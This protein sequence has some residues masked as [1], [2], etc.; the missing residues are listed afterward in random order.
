MEDIYNDMYVPVPGLFG[1]RFKQIKRDLQPDLLKNYLIEN[2]L[3]NRE[4][5][6]YYLS[7]Y[8]NF[9]SRL[10]EKETKITYEFNEKLDR[11]S[12]EF[13]SNSTKMKIH[14]N[15]NFNINDKIN[16][17]GFIPI[18]RSLKI[19]INNTHYLQFRENSRFAKLI[20]PEFSSSDDTLKEF[21]L[22]F[23]TQNHG[24]ISP[25]E[26]DLYIKINN[27]IG[28]DD[29]IGNIHINYVNDKHK[30]QI[31]CPDKEW[32]EGY[33]YEYN[34]FYIDLKKQFYGISN[35][36]NCTIEIYFYYFC[37]ISID[38]INSCHSIVETTKKF[39]CIDL[40]REP[41]F[42][43]ESKSLRYGNNIFIN[44]IKNIEC[45]YPNPNHYVYKL[46]TS[47]NNVVAA[48]LVNTVFPN[49][50]K[51]IT[52][53]NNKLCWEYR[54]KKQINTLIIPEGEYNI[55]DICH[56]INKHP[57][58]KISFN[59]NT[60]QISFTCK[61][62]IILKK[63][64]I[65]VDPNIDEDTDDDNF[66]IIIKH[67]K[68]NLCVNDKIIISNSLSFMGIC[69]QI[70]NREH[71]II[72]IKNDDTYVIQVCGI[73]LL[74]KKINNCG[75]NVVEICYPV[76]FRLRFDQKNNIS[77]IL[78][79]DAQ[80]TEFNCTQTNK[81]FNQKEKIIYHHNTYF[82]MTC[83]KLTS[84]TNSGKIKDFFSKIL[85]CEN[86]RYLFDTFVDSPIYL[87]NPIPTLYE[88]EFSFYDP[89][90]E[91]YDFEYHDHN[92]VIEFITQTELPKGTNI[93]PELGVIN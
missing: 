17:S 66:K 28:I 30:L 45:G 7:K 52:N 27:F 10:R 80:L 43:K 26:Q 19:K 90:G 68:H 83:D 4:N 36:V 82:I 64:F 23:N 59:K 29:H 35:P 54:N 71:T 13:T 63:P 9:D 6:L 31:L 53:K 79:F 8:V 18:K 37:G 11:E 84:V 69:E 60:H 46:E 62:K 20:F 85:L 47:L 16:F 40:F 70:I 32:Y 88:L 39:V 92:F 56:E 2:G 65:N 51:N 44:K 87:P 74:E 57:N 61:E 1:D 12:I 33:H 72:E 81:Y 55:D 14:H 42:C 50:E 5:N 21:R 34:T 67:T 77:N 78:G 89:D 76:S 49:V 58:I 25:Y 48:R 15:N 38:R 91:P 75:G 86:K 41:K 93:N 24:E 3:S 22:S 73:N